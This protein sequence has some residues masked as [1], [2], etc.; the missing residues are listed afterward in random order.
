LGAVIDRGRQR[1]T[2]LS[3]EDAFGESSGLLGA[4]RL[5][6]QLA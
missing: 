2:D 6:D 1:R 3:P 4:E 5:E